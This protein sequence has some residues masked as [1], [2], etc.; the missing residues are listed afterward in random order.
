MVPL[1]CQM[2]KNKGLT[3]KRKKID[4]N[5]RVK[6][7]EKFRRAK[8]R[9]KGQVRTRLSVFCLCCC[10]CD[11]NPPA[12]V[13]SRISNPSSRS[14]RSGARRPDTAERCLG[15]APELRRASSLSSPERTQKALLCLCREH[16]W[17]AMSAFN[18]CLYYTV[19]ASQSR[20]CRTM[21]WLVCVLS[22]CAKQINIFILQTF[23][24]V[25]VVHAESELR[26]LKQKERCVVMTSMMVQ[27][28]QARTKAEQSRRL[29][30][31]LRCELPSDKLLV[32]RCQVANDAFL[33]LH[34]VLHVLVG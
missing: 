32:R 20:C 25:C 23:M 31:G 21:P 19:C 24:I 6:H 14:E 15:F 7:R 22:D 28:Q 17:T 3:P 16:P 2:A 34:L 33:N 11:T 9:R 30:S 27:K 18:V 29:G 4:R 8:I 1:P 12:P 10:L 13:T 26:T 5:P